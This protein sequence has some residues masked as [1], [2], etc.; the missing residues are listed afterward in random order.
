MEG[1]DHARQAAVKARMVKAVAEEVLSF[2]FVVG[3]EGVGSGRGRGTSGREKGEKGI[4]KG[5]EMIMQGR[6]RSRRGW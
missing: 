5:R 2:S 6:R 4:G 3:G 1:D